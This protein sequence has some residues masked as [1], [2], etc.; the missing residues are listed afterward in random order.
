MALTLADYEKQATVPLKKFLLTNLLRYCDLLSLV[1]FEKVTALN[2]VVTRWKTLPSVDFRQIGGTYTES[3]GTTEQVTE[4]VYALGGEIKFDRV[5]G[6]LKN[7]IEDPQKTQTLMK[8]RAAAFQFN[9]TFINGDH[10]NDVDSPEGLNKRIAS[11][12]PSRQSISIGASYDVTVSSA[13]MNN[14]ID[15]IHEII[16]LAGLRSAPTVIVKKGDRQPAKRGALLMNRGLL[17]GIGKV[18]RRVS[19]A[20]LN[21]TQDS[22]GRLFHSFDGIPMI[23]VGLKADQSTEIITNTYG[24]GADETR[25]FAVRFGSEDGLSGIQLNSPDLYDPIKA[26][27][28][29]ANTTGPQKLLRMDWWWGLAGYGSYYAARLTGVQDPSTWT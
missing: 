20:L 24:A 5:F 23:D 27:E 19:P 10:V 12:L 11:Y 13:T 28:G 22:Y 1:P 3:T 18:L 17:L 16:E 14:F 2:G 7:N 26:G 6:M 4:G 8:I 29:A 25:M 15:H 9:D 21:T